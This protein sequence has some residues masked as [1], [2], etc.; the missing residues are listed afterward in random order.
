MICRD[1]DYTIVTR[2]APKPGA[3]KVVIKVIS[4]VINPGENICRNALNFEGYPLGSEGCGTI[5]SVG[6]GVSQELIG[7]KVS[8]SACSNPTVFEG[9]LDP[10]QGSFS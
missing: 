9:K 4:A 8:F 5:V 7:S 6:E 2:D 10:Y 3:G 1:G